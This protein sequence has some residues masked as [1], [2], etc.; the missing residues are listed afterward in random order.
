M[1]F[2]LRKKIYSVNFR[3]W[4]DFGRGGGLDISNQP[5]S[6]PTAGIALIRATAHPHPWRMARPLK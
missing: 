3:S 1:F 6:Q 5:E 2:H 4:G